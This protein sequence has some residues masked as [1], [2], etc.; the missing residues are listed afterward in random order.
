MKPFDRGSVMVTISKRNLVGAGLLL[1]AGLAVGFNSCSEQPDRLARFDATVDG[2]WRKNWKWV[3]AIPF[4]EAGGQYADEGDRKKSSLDRDHILPLLKR[5]QD[6]HQ[7]RWQA[8]VDK[9]KT[10]LA[11][12]I[13]AELSSEPGVVDAIETSLAEEQKT[14][15][16]VVLIQVGHRWLTVEFLNERQS[17]RLL[18]MDK[19]SGG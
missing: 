15:P 6:R 1:A 2:S 10:R 17:K 18:E 16:G 14:F 19:Q 9:K 3:E 11:V 4:F 8:V 5:M 7:L 13:V 12:A